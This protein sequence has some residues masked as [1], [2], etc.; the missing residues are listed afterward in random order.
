MHERRPAS[1]TQADVA[2]IVAGAKQA[3]ATKI[4]IYLGEARVV[5]WLQSSA[6][7]QLELVEHEAPRL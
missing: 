6:D 2:R 7:D 3:G 4:E 5:V 1:I